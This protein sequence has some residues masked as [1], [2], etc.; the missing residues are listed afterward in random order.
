MRTNEKRGIRWAIFRFFGPQEVQNLVNYIDQQLEMTGS[1]S[2]V[3][4]PLGE[5][6]FNVKTSLD[7]ELKPLV[8]PTR[9]ERASFQAGLSYGVSL[10]GGT[11]AAMN[12]EDFE[13]LDEMQKKSTHGGG[14]QRNN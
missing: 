9:Q 6:P 10:M 14:G 12:E 7:D 2:I 8:F 4:Y 11:T 3:V 5:F 1:D 13:A